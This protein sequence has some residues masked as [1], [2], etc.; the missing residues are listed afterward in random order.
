MKEYAISNVI[1]MK[2]NLTL[3]LI[4]QQKQYSSNDQ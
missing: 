1:K 3:T 2:A 4:S